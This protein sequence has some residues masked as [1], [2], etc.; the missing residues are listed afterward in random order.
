[1]G[2]MARKI[3]R[4]SFIAAFMLMFLF[5]FSLP[6]IKAA[7]AYT[8]TVTAGRTVPADLSVGGDVNSSPSGISCTDG[9]SGVCSYLFSD[10]IEINLAA[11][12]N[13]KSNFY[14]WGVPCTAA[15]TGPCVFTPGANSVINA[16]FSPNYHATV[17]GHS[18]LEYTTLTEAYAN[19]DEGNAVA[20]HVYVFQE[21]LILNRAIPVILDGGKGDMY[22]TN[23][24][25][26]TLQGTLEIQ[27]GSVEVHSLIIQ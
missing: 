13:W 1:M 17:L 23:V 2:S 20:A 14:G 18:V 7:D 26:T 5:S 16:T 10:G 12:P 27:Q 8:V 11:N 25:F 19:A 15:G 24:G 4:R 9:S 22:L 3:Y 21:D 6:L